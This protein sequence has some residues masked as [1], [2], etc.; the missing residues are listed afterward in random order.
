MFTDESTVVL[1]LS[2]HGI[3]RQRG[4]HPPESFYWK[5]HH[6]VHVMVWGGGAIGP[7]CFRTDLVRCPH[8]LTAYNYCELLADNHVFYQCSRL[9]NYIWQQDAPPPHRA[10]ANLIK[11]HVP[12]MMVW[13]PYSP[14]LSPIE[15]VWAYLNQKL[16]G[17]SF[18][19]ADQLF[20]KIRDEWRRIP[21]SI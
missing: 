8:S 1:D 18:E 12:N 10:V 3:W 5:D 9:G 4:F 17:Q 13:P 19:T 21:N 6:P 16:R 7:S 11:N 15:Q 2:R 20:E 14:D